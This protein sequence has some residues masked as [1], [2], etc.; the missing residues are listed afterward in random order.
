MITLPSPAR[1]P[2]HNGCAHCDEK[3]VQVR[4]FRKPDQG[5]ADFVL[6]GASAVSGLLKLYADLN[7]SADQVTAPGCREL[8]NG[9]VA[10]WSP[11]KKPSAFTV[12]LSHE[13]AGLPPAGAQFTLT[14][15]ELGEI[16]NAVASHTEAAQ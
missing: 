14:L 4:R 10:Y 2:L 11:V 3:C 6:R 1:V 16:V 13:P 7:T 9:F 12:T 5:G 8:G 15:G